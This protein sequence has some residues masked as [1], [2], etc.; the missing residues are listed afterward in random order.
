M[1][2]ASL[3]DGPQVLR[4]TIVMDNQQ[5]IN[6]FFNSQQ[7]RPRFMEAIKEEKPW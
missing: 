3:D 7:P 6:N 4:R 1:N 2:S 5:P